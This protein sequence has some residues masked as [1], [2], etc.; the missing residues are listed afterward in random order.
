MRLIHIYSKYQSCTFG[1]IPISFGDSVRRAVHSFGKL[2]GCI[3]A[4]MSMYRR[5]VIA[6]ISSKAMYI[7]EIPVFN[8]PSEI[9]FKNNLV[10]YIIDP[11]FVRP[12]GR[13]RETQ[14]LFWGEMSENALVC[15][16]RRMMRFVN[17][18]SFEFIGRK[19]LQTTCNR[20]HRSGNYLLAMRRLRSHLN[21]L[22]T[23]EIFQRLPNKF[24]S[25]RQDKHSPASGNISECN[26]LSQAR[27]H[28]HQIATV[29]L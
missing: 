3:V 26:S 9:P 8:A 4:H 22:R 21:A 28:L 11:C 29:R 16:R 17:Y 12:V 24:L 18:D 15:S 27:C 14:H 20:L 23:V 19:S 6:Y 13:S 5:Q 7:T 1:I 25:V 2:P 10:K